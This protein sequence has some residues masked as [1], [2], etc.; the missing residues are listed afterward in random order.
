MVKVYPLAVRSLFAH[1]VY[2]DWIAWEARQCVKQPPNEWTPSAKQTHIKSSTHFREL[3]MNTQ[4]YIVCTNFKINLL[5]SNYISI[6]NWF[7]KTRHLFTLYLNP[8]QRNMRNFCSFLIFLKSYDFPTVRRG[9]FYLLYPCAM[10]H[11]WGNLF[12]FDK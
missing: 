8:C 5:H 11:M 2:V 1:F 4:Q 9:F 3:N 10:A 7:F 6:L 12:T